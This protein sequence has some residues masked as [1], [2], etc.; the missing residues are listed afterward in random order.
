MLRSVRQKAT[1]FHWIMELFVVF[2]G[3]LIALAA[4]GWAEDRSA[5]ARA[6][7]AEIR[8]REE[9]QGNIGLGVERIALHQC[10]KDR[11]TALA[12]GLGTGRPEWNSA[13]IAVPSEEEGWLAFDRFYRVP[14]RTWVTSAYDGSLASGALDALPAA[15]AGELSYAYSTMKAINSLNDEE[16]QSAASLA[17]LGFDRPLSEE[18][19]QHLL[20]VLTQLDYLNASI[21][22]MSKQRLKAYLQ[23]YPLTREERTELRGSAPVAIAGWRRIYGSCVDPG[24]LR[25]LDPNLQV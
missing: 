7:A 6:R 17:V 12:D 4:Q 10:V 3:V 25:A 1:V 21:V 15:R 16:Q 18:K 9:L 23:L 22:I 13:R 2:A 8:I 24:A 19:R 14:S 20:S 11:L 5:K